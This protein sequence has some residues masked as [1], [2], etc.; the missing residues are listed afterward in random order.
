MI[1]CFIS[2]VSGPR[3]A[4]ACF[5]VSGGE[6]FVV[7]WNIWNEIY[8]RGVIGGKEGNLLQKLTYKASAILSQFYHSR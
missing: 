1:Q 8:G 2:V 6:F 7:L 4:V 5:A 3:G